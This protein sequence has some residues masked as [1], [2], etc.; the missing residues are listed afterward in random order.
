M[1]PTTDPFGPF[2]ADDAATYEAM[3]LAD[4]L[5]RIKRD[6]GGGG[7]LVQRDLLSAMER[8]TTDEQ[9]AALLRSHGLDARVMPVLN[10]PFSGGDR[11]KC[12]CDGL[13]IGWNGLVY[14]HFPVCG[15][16]QT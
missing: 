9:L 11:A 6:Q 14:N 13:V 1:T 4:Q 7:Y 2:Y 15:W 12:V 10:G 16:P 5:A 3:S 8:C